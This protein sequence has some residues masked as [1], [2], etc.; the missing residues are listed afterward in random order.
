MPREATGELRHLADG[1]AAR[2]TLEGRTRRDFVLETCADEPAAVERCKA[3]ASLAVRLRK[4]G[5]ADQIEEL[6]KMG[7]KARAGRPWEAVC[8]AVETLCAGHARE[9]GRGAVPLF[10]AWA[11]SWTDGELAKKYPDHVKAKR[12]SSDD[13]QRLGKHVLPHL[14]GVR[15]DEF[16]LDH[17][18]FVMANLSS[19]LSPGSRRQIAQTM[20]RLM[21]LAVY[22][23]KWR[24]DNPIPAGW[25]PRNGDARAKECLYPDEDALLMRGQAAQGGQP[26][27]PLLRRL[28]YG[29]LAREGMRTDEMAALRWRDV[30]IERGRI[31]LDKNKTDDPRDWNL[32][33]DVIEALKRW[34]GRQPCTEPND[35][36]FA[37]EGVPISVQHLADRLRRDLRRVGVTRPQL[38][39]RSDV[40]QPLRAHDLRATFVTIALAV[41]KTETWISDRTGH[42]SHKMIDAYRR[43][44]RSWDLGELGP[45]SE[46]IPELS[47]TPKVSGGSGPIT[48]RI[49]HAATIQA[50]SQTLNR[51]CITSPSRTT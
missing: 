29:F 10:S 25:L 19:E 49:P 11:K 40:R 12:S 7:A 43:K 18:E 21:R 47:E 8:V 6:L 36:V 17:A 5:H 3:L 33:P 26:G 20:A 44:A 31:N 45:L 24:K 35:H 23:G 48:P 2:I 16:T 9:K 50:N 30:D 22:P 41:G 38:F 51:K 1:F 14:D 46:L 39:E 37:D 34:K 42:H 4:A 32:R 27:V 28:A 15:V 13:A